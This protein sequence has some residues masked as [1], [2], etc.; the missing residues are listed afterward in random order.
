[1]ARFTFARGNAKSSSP[2]PSMPLA[3]WPACS[4]R[5][6]R[7]LLGVRLRFRARR[8]RSRPR[9]ARTGGRPEPRLTWLARDSPG[10][11]PG[12]GTR[13]ACSAAIRVAGV[14][15]HPAGRGHRRHT[16]ARR[17]EP[18][19]RSRCLHRAAVAR[20]PA[21]ADPAR[22]RGDLRRARVAAAACCEA[23]IDATP[24]RFGCCPRHPNSLQR[25][26]RTAFGLPA[27]RVVVTGDPRDDVLLAGTEESRVAR[28]AS[29]SSA[30][31]R[32]RG[33]TGGAVRAHLARRRARPRRSER[34]RVAGDRRVPRGARRC[35]SCCGRIRTVSATTTPGPQRRPESGCSPP[36]PRTTSP[37]CCPP[38]PPRHRLLVDRLRLRTDRAPDRVPR[39]RR[40]R[41]HRHPR[42]LRAVREVQRRHRSCVVARAAAA[43]RTR[44]QRPSD[45]AE[46]RVAQLAA[47]LR[48]S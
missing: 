9:A 27:D 5:A 30:R 47:R 10:I 31:G 28:R 20:H 45:A 46:A 17:C 18:F 14:A 3:E 37:R 26:L 32:A 35:C 23:C 34:R 8:G 43:A 7:Q 22:L 24:R 4:C 15:A 29:C 6:P 13:P 40:R 33:L 2:S 21:Q 39:P 36:P 16:R 19:R 38:R 11:A 1:M 25:R 42:T 48:V 41:V 12:G 44:R